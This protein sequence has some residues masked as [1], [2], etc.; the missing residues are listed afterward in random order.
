MVLSWSSAVL[1]F[2]NRSHGS[3]IPISRTLIMDMVSEPSSIKRPTC[4][5]CSKPTRI[6]LCNRLKSPILHNSIAVTILQHGLEKKHPLNSAR[7]AKIGLKNVHIITVSDVNAQAKFLIRFRDAHHLFDE[8]PKRN[9]DGCVQKYD[10]GSFTCEHDVSID[11]MIEQYGAIN[12]FT[13]S[14]MPS[15][16]DFNQFVASYNRENSFMVKKLLVDISK[17]DSECE[18]FDIKIPHG[19]ALLFPSDESVDVEVVDFEVKNLIVLDGTW[20]KARRMYKENPWLKMLPHIRL[21][22]DRLS[23]YR[24]VRNQPRAGYLSTIESIVYALKALGED[25]SEGLDGLLNVFESMVGDQRRCK[26]ERLSKQSKAS[27]SG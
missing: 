20:A 12:S 15:I 27:S 14:E 5:V 24:E 17:E 9:Y 6:C 18:E 11:F 19:S 13:H 23:L 3:S 25:P 22:I 16:T 7:I 8:M 1:S 4:T 2:P 26:D 10:L 21:D